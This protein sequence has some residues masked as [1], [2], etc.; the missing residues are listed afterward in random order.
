VWFQLLLLEEQQCEAVKHSSLEKTV[1]V[2]G[3]SITRANI[4][5]VTVAFGGHNNSRSRKGFPHQNQK[6]GHLTQIPDGHRQNTPWCPKN[7]LL[8]RVLVDIR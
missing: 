4:L 7:L 1:H 8:I 6:G 3:I 5:G 2:G